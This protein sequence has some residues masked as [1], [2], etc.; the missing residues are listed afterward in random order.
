ME[1]GL[2]ETTGVEIESEIKTEHVQGPC[3]HHDDVL[4][5]PCK[6]L[7]V[8]EEK[9]IPKVSADIF[10]NVHGHGVRGGSVSLGGCVDPGVR[11]RSA[12]CCVKVNGTWVR[13]KSVR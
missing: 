5:N 10:G 6:D 2:E 11:G 4:A 8:C 1:I 12:A 13:E 9:R 7:Q 3:L